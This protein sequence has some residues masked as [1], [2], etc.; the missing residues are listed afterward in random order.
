MFGVT[1]WEVF[2]LCEHPWPNMTAAEV[3]K[4]FIIVKDYRKINKLYN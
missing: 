2:T 3:F 1:V 4:F